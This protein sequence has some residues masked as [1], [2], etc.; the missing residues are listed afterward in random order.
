MTRYLDP[1]EAHFSLKQQEDGAD[2]EGGA[3]VAEEG[4]QGEGNEDF[5]RGELVPC[6]HVGQEGDGHEQRQSH[7]KVEGCGQRPDHAAN[8]DEVHLLPTRTKIID[9]YTVAKSSP[10][11][12]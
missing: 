2:E 6:A 8:L 7:T 11:Q 12:K 9:Q 10:I 5:A 3:D 1:C 4:E